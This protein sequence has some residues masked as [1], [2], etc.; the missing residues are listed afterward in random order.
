MRR[1]SSL[2]DAVKDVKI[3]SSDK[4]ELLGEERAKTKEDE[5]TEEE[6]AKLD[7]LIATKASENWQEKLIGGLNA[8]KEIITEDGAEPVFVSAGKVYKLSGEDDVETFETC[9]GPALLV[10]VR[11]RRATR[12]AVPRSQRL[13]RLP[14]AR[15]AYLQ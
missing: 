4:K 15:G 8:V 13:L 2:A 7:E 5:L 9:R 6:K 3:S 12:K 14:H 10:E 1:G 11:P